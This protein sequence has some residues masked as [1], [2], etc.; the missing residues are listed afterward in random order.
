[1]STDIQ[2]VTGSDMAAILKEQEKKDIA[3]AKRDSKK[4][5][6]QCCFG[7]ADT[8]SPRCRNQ[9]VTADTY[10]GFTTGLSW[11]AEHNQK[12]WLSNWPH[13]QITMP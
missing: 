2:Y 13:A 4:P 10:H 12:E 6:R 1:M 11:C 9:S 3:K 7:I 5:Q 8:H